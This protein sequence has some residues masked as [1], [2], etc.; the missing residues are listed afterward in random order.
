MILPLVLLLVVAAGSADRP[1]ELA[2]YPDSESLR[3]HRARQYI[4]EGARL[5]AVAELHRVLR[6]TAADLRE[7]E[8]AR[9]LLSKIYLEEARYHSRN[10]DGNRAGRWLREARKMGYAAPDARN[11]GLP[12]SDAVA[13][14]RSA[15]SALDENRAAEAAAL[16]SRLAGPQPAA[17]YALR[18][19][20]ALLMNRM[21]VMEKNLRRASAIDSADPVLGRFWK[22]RSL[23][24][25]RALSERG[26]ISPAIRELHAADS[27]L[28]VVALLKADLHLRAADT[29]SAVAEF[30]AISRRPD[31][32]GWIPAKLAKLYLDLDM[33]E[34]LLTR[35][36]RWDLMPRDPDKLMNIGRAFLDHGDTPRAS[37]CFRLLL[38]LAPSTAEAWSIMGR[39]RYSLGDYA[40]A[41][42]NFD[43]ARR[44]GDTSVLPRLL[45]SLSRSGR[46]DLLARELARISSESRAVAMSHPLPAVAPAPRENPVL[47]S[48]SIGAASK[49]PDSGLRRVS[50]ESPAVSRSGHIPESTLVDRIRSL[51]AAGNHDTVLRLARQALV[52]DP[53]H[54]ETRLLMAQAYWRKG[55]FGD[56]MSI[57][58]PIRSI[59]PPGAQRARLL[60]AQGTAALSLGLLDDARMSLAEAYAFASNTKDTSSIDNIAL[61]LAIVLKRSGDPDQALAILDRHNIRTMEGNLVRA[62]SLDMMERS[63]EAISLLEAAAAVS[64]VAALN[65]GILLRKNGMVDESIMVFEELDKSWKEEALVAY[66]YARSLETAQDFE[67]AKKYYEIAS[68]LERDPSLAEIFR[69]ES[70]RF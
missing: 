56:A 54:V 40:A 41:A 50:A 21:D 29:R 61:N 25:A 32:P 17:T 62:A 16:L 51:A 69:K 14:H 4:Q 43:M 24:R 27:R 70:L 18:A 66:H 30:D 59:V 5:E 15:A 22:T 49:P 2:G 6:D 33:M 8:P 67:A 45:D 58:K 26:E 34:Q 3:I 63:G 36:D 53:F 10:G 42:F 19:E 48:A 47:V 65:Y 37:Q 44:N 11:S 12:S 57:L 28:L 1:A 13:L 20:A 68:R 52:L 23:H 46:K 64:P 60:A 38:K 39:V 7:K 9:L 55:R 31:A 35:F